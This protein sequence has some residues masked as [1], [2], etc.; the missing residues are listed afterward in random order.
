MKKKI[1]K[2]MIAVAAIGIAGGILWYLYLNY[3]PNYFKK[4]S[5]FDAAA[6]SEGLEVF[7]QKSGVKETCGETEIQITE[8]KAQISRSG[9]GVLPYE[10]NTVEVGEWFKVEMESMGWNFAYCVNNV[11]F[12]KEAIDTDAIYYLEKY[13]MVEL[14]EKYT[15][16]NEYTY[17][18]AN[19][20]VKNN[21]MKE[22]GIYVNSILYVPY[23]E[24]IEDIEHPFNAGYCLGYKTS[25]DL[26]DDDKDYAKVMLKQGEEFTCNLVYLLEDKDVEG[27]IPYLRYSL[28]SVDKKYD[29]PYVRIVL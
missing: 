5:F 24:E 9:L 4:D 14:D 17:L 20:T 11:M 23:N 27:K 8:T 3:L 28:G 29:T 6:M 15:I 12:T 13:P 19:V 25:E 18:V 7:S 10:G 16:L 22:D 2:I 21:G 26:P 1:S